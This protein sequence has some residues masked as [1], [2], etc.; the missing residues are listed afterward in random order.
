ML[1]NLNY[2]AKSRLFIAP[3]F[4]TL[5]I[6]LRVPSAD[7]LNR[8]AAQLAL[9]GRTPRA[10]LRDSNSARLNL[11]FLA[12]DRGGAHGMEKQ[13]QCAL[14]THQSQIPKRVGT[15]CPPSNLACEVDFEFAVAFDFRF[16]LPSSATE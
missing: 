7:T 6:A 13:K 12:T 16:T 10:P 3:R 14:C 5:C 15:K 1:R 11:R 4:S 8:A 2:Q 9:A